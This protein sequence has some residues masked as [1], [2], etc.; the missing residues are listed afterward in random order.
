[1]TAILNEVRMKF[2]EQ[3]QTILIS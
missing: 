2:K 3:K 1:M